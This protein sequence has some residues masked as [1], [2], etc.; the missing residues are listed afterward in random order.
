MQLK[1][2][3]ILFAGIIWIISGLVLVTSYQIPQGLDNIDQILCQEQCTEV[4][5]CP[6]P[7][8]SA[9]E[10]TNEFSITFSVSSCNLNP[11]LNNNLVYQ[12]CLV[13]CLLPV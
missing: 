7:L 3:F 8:Q 9:P 10:Q 5:Y 4:A 13:N 11:E 1:G 2:E 6:F 12:S